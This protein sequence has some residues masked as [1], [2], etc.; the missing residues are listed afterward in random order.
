[1]LPYAYAYAE[2][3]QNL[4]FFMQFKK[5]EYPLF[6]L[7]LI[8][9]KLLKSD[10]FSFITILSH[11]QPNI[12]HLISGFRIALIN[13]LTCH[14][15]INILKVKKESSCIFYDCIRVL[16]NENEFSTWKQLGIING[17]PK[18]DPKRVMCK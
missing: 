4:I 17:K 8:D 16:K 10:I 9:F 5:Q 1:M 13:M 15:R 12:Y 2:L 7:P 3:P 18:L 14:N 6:L 11:E